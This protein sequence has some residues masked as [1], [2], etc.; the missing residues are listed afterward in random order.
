ML[1]AL[2]LTTALAVPAHTGYVTDTA[3]ILS[4]ADRERLNATLIAYRDRT[5]NEFAVLIIPTLA[6]E[7]LR[8]YANRVFHTWGIGIKGKDNGVLLL[9]ST[10]DRKVRLEVGTGL[11]P[12]L[13]DGRAGQII[14]EHILPAFRAGQ[15]MTGL[16]SGVNA[17]IAQLDTAHEPAPVKSASESDGLSGFAWLLILLGVAS[18]VAVVAGI[19]IWR[20]KRR[21]QRELEED[22]ARLN[23]YRERARERVTYAAPPSIRSYPSRASSVPSR[24]S[25]NPSRSSYVAP[26][27]EPSRWEPSSSPSTPS[28]DTSTY[29][30]GDSGGGGADGS[31]N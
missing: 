24:P 14:R 2:V 13:P 5:T 18:G 1:L 23:K 10:G 31:Y 9:W 26:A 17:V 4:A 22:A 25:S 30:G 28:V 3:S 20:A 7:D 29:S 27:P 16:S 21:L 6:G 8:E 12:V 15:W 19:V 11:E